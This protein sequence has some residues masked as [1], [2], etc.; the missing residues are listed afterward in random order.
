MGRAVLL[1]LLAIFSFWSVSIVRA[2]D[3][4]KYYTW[5]VTYGT[6]S[7]LGPSQQV[8]NGSGSLLKRVCVCVCEKEY[9]NSV[10]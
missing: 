6:A 2:E 9:W 1:S 10:S 4:Y 8:S 3:A 5:T 7:P